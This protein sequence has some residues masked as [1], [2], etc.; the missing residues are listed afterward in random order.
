MYRRV[1]FTCL[2][3]TREFVTYGCLKKARINIS[4][5][6][7]GT[8]LFTCQRELNIGRWRHWL[9]AVR[10]LLNSRRTLEGESFFSDYLRPLNIPPLEVSPKVSRQDLSLQL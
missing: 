2:F 5:G 8:L 3:S 4:K 9:L 6:L 7:K 10:N 1:S